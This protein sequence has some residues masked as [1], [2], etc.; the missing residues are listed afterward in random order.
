[1]D[2]L[3]TECELWAP[4]EFWMLPEEEKEAY[5]CGPGRGI[6]EKL[7]P[8]KW[9]FGWPLVPVLVVTPSCQIHDFCYAWG[10]DDIEWKQVSDRAFRNNMVRQ[11]E[12]AASKY[13]RVFYPVTLLRLR[14]AR[15]YYEVVDRFGG[16]AFWKG[17]NP[18]SEMAM[19]KCFA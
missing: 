8:D 9:R 14:K 10:P 4:S 18:A 2:I 1:M 12:H 7:V 11:V 6:L 5:R 17:R 19:I 15:L 16:P 13:S 3:K